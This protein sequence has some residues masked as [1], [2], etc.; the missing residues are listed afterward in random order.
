[1]NSDVIKSLNECLDNLGLS[2]TYVIDDD[3]IKIIIYRK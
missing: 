2:F 3:K 1:M